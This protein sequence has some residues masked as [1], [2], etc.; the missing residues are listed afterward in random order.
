MFK[1][2]LV[3]TDGSRLSLKGAKV[4]IRLAKALRARVTAVYVIPPFKEPDAALELLTA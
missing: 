3:P 2:I 4:G 1:H